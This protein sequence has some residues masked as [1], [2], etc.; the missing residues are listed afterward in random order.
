MI[1]MTRRQCGCGW[2]LP[3]ERPDG[4]LLMTHFLFKHPEIFGPDEH[5][6]IEE[7]LAT[8]SVEDLERAL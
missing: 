7:F 1:K 4:K 6:R 5:G 8:V 3:V 2:Q